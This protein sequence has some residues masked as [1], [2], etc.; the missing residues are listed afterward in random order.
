MTVQGVSYMHLVRSASKHGWLLVPNI[1]LLLD[2]STDRIKIIQKWK[3]LSD[4]SIEAQKHHDIDYLLLDAKLLA[5]S[6]I[7]HPNFD[8]SSSC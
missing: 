1:H 6:R 4:F 2:V 3:L 5:T 7:E 8:E